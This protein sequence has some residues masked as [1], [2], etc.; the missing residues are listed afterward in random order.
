MLI[1]SQDDGSEDDNLPLLTIVGVSV[2]AASLFVATLTLVLLYKLYFLLSFVFNLIQS[3]A[4]ECE[5]SGA[6]HLDTVLKRC[7]VMS[8]QPVG[9]S[10]KT[11]VLGSGS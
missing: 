8:L 11:S 2:A 5:Q 6:V 4:R 1:F 9:T 10:R 7:S 3:L